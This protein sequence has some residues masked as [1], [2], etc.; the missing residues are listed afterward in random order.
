M[1]CMRLV[2]V[3][4]YGVCMSTQVGKGHQVIRGGE[5]GGGRRW[6]GLGKKRRSR[7]EDMEEKDGGGGREERGRKKCMRNVCA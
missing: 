4:L 1:C 7:E 5:N 3:L 2:S 6:K